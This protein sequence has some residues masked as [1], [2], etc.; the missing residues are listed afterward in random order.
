M[1]TMRWFVRSTVDESIIDGPFIKKHDADMARAEFEKYY[2]A[3]AY[4]REESIDD[5]MERDCDPVEIE[6]ESVS[7]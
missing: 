7:V 3:K 4:M 2:R 1:P 6:G 5:P